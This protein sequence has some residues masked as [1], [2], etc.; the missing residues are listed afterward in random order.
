MISPSLQSFSPGRK[1]VCS[2]MRKLWVMKHEWISM[3]QKTNFKQQC[4]VRW[5][6]GVKRWRSRRSSWLQIRTSMTQRHTRHTH[7][8]G[9]PPR[10][11][12]RGGA[13]LLHLTGVHASAID[14]KK[15]HG[16]SI[17]QE[18][19]SWIFRS[20]DYPREGVARMK[21][22]RLGVSLAPLFFGSVG[23]DP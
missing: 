1:S 4:T 11:P 3:I 14:K 22:E 2:D 12:P 15:G 16:R 10:F 9:A 8:K 5:I 7:T 23:C 17:V 21:A 18:L 19:V 6:T 20:C 13:E